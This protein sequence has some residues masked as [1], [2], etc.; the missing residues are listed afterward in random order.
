MA[1]GQKIWT[2]AYYY[3]FETI[4][5]SLFLGFVIYSIFFGAAAIVW[6]DSGVIFGLLSGCLPTQ[7][8]STGSIPGATYDFAGVMVFTLG[9]ALAFVAIVLMILALG[10][11]RGRATRC[12]I[13]SLHARSI[14]F[15]ISA[16]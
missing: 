16:F 15:M 6:I 8:A 7:P 5:F 3:S 9:Q 4:G 2:I 11:W 10:M 14:D 13:Q 1:D 12:M